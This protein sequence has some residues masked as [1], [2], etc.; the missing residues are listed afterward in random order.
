MCD[1]SWADPSDTS[2]SK[3]AGGRWNPPG[4]FGALYLN[5]TVEVAMANARRHVASL[6]GDDVTLYDLSLGMRPDLQHYGVREHSFVDAVTKAGLESIGLAGAYPHDAP[7]GLCR[8][9]A[10]EAYS[11][12]EAG[13][14]ARSAPHPA[15][16]EL[17]IFDRA[18]K[19]LA[20][21]RKRQ[22]FAQW[23]GP[24]SAP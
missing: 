2:F 23:Y 1:P 12:E 20:R 18:V 9:I 7:P 21:K 10:R 3:R 16:E 14:A 4:E 15:G 22:R 24:I 17:A 8:S 19:Q 5:R 13:I 6:F 11:M